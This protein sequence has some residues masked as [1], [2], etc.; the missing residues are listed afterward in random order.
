MV[1]SNT[2][3]QNSHETL[4][5]EEEV[6]AAPCTAKTEEGNTAHDLA[7]GFQPGELGSIITKEGDPVDGATLETKAQ[8]QT[9]LK[10]QVSI[11]GMPLL[12]APL[13]HSN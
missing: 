3:A 12:F 1:H 11:A 5:H 8:D 9:H 6:G 2:T 4:R 13:P 7:A 10:K